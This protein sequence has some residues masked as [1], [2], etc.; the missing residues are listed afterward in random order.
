MQTDETACT[1]VM[2]YRGAN[3]QF[4]P[5]WDQTFGVSVA[6]EPSVVHNALLTSS[7]DA[8]VIK[9]VMKVDGDKGLR[10]AAK[11]HNIDIMDCTN[12]SSENV[13]KHASGSA[14][15]QGERWR[16]VCRQP[17]KAKSDALR[18]QLL[19]TIQA[20]TDKQY[21]RETSSVAHHPS[22]QSAGNIGHDT[23]QNAAESNNNTTE[24]IRNAATGLEAMLA[25]FN[26]VSSQFFSTREDIKKHKEYL[27]PRVKDTLA[28][29]RH[30]NSQ[31][32]KGDLVWIGNKAGKMSAETKSRKHLGQHET[33][34]LQRVK[35]HPNGRVLINCTI[36]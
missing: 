26:L 34:H 36:M 6:S 19:P 35:Y 27:P 22:L 32:G 16:A 33:C 12:H 10:E 23:S 28:E 11:K 4:N 8:N 14:D 31:Y 15:I 29:S 30:R 20:Y 2:E 13:K 17:N 18:A 7:T 5:G 25:A 24:K 9:S 1:Q 21:S 3:E